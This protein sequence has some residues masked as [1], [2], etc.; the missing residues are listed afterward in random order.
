M[1]VRG[2]QTIKWGENEITDIEDISVE[3]EVDSEDFQTLQGNTYEVDGPMKVTATVTLLATDIASLAVLLPQYFVANGQVL[4]TGETV[5]DEEGAIDVRAA[6]CDEELIF[7]NLDIES[8]SD[9][10]NVLRLVNCRTKVD[11][12]EVDNKIRKVMIKFV[13]E[14]ASGEATMQFFKAG[15]ISDVS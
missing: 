14:T 6:S 9:P 11:G 5:T 15:G 12:V 10:A 3:H 4:S 13:G 7:N 2:P 1:L 8:C